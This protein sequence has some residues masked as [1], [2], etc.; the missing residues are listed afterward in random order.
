MR[1][2]GRAVVFRTIEDYKRRIVDPNLEVD[3]NSV[4]VLQN[5]GPK[6]YPGMAEVGNMGLPPKLLARGIKDMVRISDA[7]MSGTAFGTVVLHVCPEAASGG[8]LALVEY[9]DFIEL[10]VEARRLRLDISGAELARRQAN[11]K[12][13]LSPI[14]GGYQ[15]M[16]VQHVMQASQGADLDFLVGCRGAAVTR[17]AH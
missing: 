12:P 3:E 13:P 16:Y 14:T 8:P 4:L 17:E 5:C 9:G 7:R 2:Y 6:G 10:D 11:W 1:H 15:Q